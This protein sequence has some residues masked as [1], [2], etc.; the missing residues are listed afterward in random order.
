MFKNHL[1]EI[2]LNHYII[3]AK[4]NNYLQH[5]ET[6]PTTAGDFYKH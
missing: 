4:Y 3:D 1:V 2:P 6:P 5:A